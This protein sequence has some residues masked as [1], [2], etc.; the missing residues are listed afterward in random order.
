MSTHRKSRD[1][2]GQYILNQNDGV[3]TIHDPAHLTENCNTDDIK[4]RELIDEFTA[5]AMLHRGDAV[6]CQHCRPGPG[7]H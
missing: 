1:M 6:A 3:D 7:A 2:D 5:E 4:G